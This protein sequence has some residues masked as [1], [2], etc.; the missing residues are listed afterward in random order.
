MTLAGFLLILFIALKLMGYIAWS[1]VWVLAPAWVPLV[2][3]LV[4]FLVAGVIA[5]VTG[6]KVS[7]KFK[8]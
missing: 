1:W 8:L 2:V 6:K 4:F 3:V 5:L 7:T